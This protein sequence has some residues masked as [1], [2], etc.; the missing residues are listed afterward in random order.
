MLIGG[1]FLRFSEN[2]NLGGLC[3]AQVGFLV[4]HLFAAVSC[5]HIVASRLVLVFPPFAAVSYP[6]LRVHKRK[7]ALKILPI[8][9][10]PKRD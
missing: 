9:I 8:P 7:L 2:R 3:P 4:L 5:Y 6:N 10:F 1:R